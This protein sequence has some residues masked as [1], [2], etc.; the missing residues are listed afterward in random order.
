MR[1]PFQ[2]GLCKYSTCAM[3]REI[4]LFSHARKLLIF[5][6]TSRAFL[7]LEGVSLQADE[8]FSIIKSCFPYV[9]KRLLGDDSPQAQQALRD[10]LY[11]AGSYLEADRLIDLADGFTT[12][13]KATKIVDEN[14]L[15]TE[16]RKGSV[17]LG[18]KAKREASV[19]EAE[20]ALTLAKDSADILLAPE[21]NLVQNLLVEESALATSAQV[22]DAISATLID[23]PQRFRESLP[24]GIGAVLPKLPLENDVKLFLKKTE[25]ELNAQ[26]LVGKINSIDSTED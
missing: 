3:C 2:S 5:R 23:G 6:Y 13:T 12:Y 11:G 8:N 18:E 1:F 15:D 20:A 14:T 25:N 10:L 26:N 7:T 24:L 21:G 19:A 4:S 16:K 22:K 17:R 9:A